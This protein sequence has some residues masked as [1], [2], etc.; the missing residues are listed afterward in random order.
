MVEAGY[1]KDS[2][3]RTHLAIRWWCYLHIKNARNQEARRGV[4]DDGFRFA[5]GGRCS[6][7]REAQNLIRR[8]QDDAR[9]EWETWIH[10]PSHVL[11]RRGELIPVN[12][13]PLELM[14]L[15]GG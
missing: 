13:L 11:G 3:T 14:E 1:E 2:L 5:R 6:T 8:A 15:T 7:P 9:T 4:P 12:E 10:Q